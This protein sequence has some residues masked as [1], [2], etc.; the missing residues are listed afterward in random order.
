MFLATEK[1]SWALAV[2]TVAATPK[3]ETARKCP[4]CLW[5]NMD[6]LLSGIGRPKSRARKSVGTAKKHR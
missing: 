3:I 1:G 4:Q 5:E 2:L 6:D